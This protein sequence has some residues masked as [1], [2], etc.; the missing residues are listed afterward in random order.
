[1]RV[2]THVNTKFAMLSKLVYSCNSDKL[3]ID[4]R[5][6][7][8]LKYLYD[9]QDNINQLYEEIKEILA[10]KKG[11]IRSALGSR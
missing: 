9:I 11:D 7:E 3:K 2:A 5:P 6:K 4:Q 8:K 1:M 10:R